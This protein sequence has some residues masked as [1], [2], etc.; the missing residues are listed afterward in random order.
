MMGQRMSCANDVSVGQAIAFSRAVEIVELELKVAPIIRQFSDA[1]AAA[2]TARLIQ[3]AGS[4]GDAS[5]VTFR[6]RGLHRPDSFPCTR[7]LLLS[8]LISP[9]RQPRHA[10][11]SSVSEGVEYHATQSALAVRKLGEMLASAQAVD[12][13]LGRRWPAFRYIIAGSRYR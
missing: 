11:F 10:R 1:G 13:R 6:R 7:P 4:S 9:R 5:A 8:W 3:M 12:H 2:S